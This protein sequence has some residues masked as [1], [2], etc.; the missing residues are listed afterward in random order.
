MQR[1][2]GPRGPRGEFGPCLVRGMEFQGEVFAPRSDGDRVFRPL[3]LSR[4]GR[5]YRGRVGEAHREQGLAVGIQ[6]G[7]P[8][9]KDEP[10]PGRGPEGWISRQQYLEGH[11]QGGT[12]VI[13][14][15]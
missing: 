14:T 10:D 12:T 1:W 3:Y 2:V 15:L 6:V 4:W 5:R 8:A 9:P 11:W 7:Y 13:K